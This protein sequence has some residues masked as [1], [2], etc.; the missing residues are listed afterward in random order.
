MARGKWWS[1]SELRILRKMYE[2]HGADISKW[3]FELDRS[4]N[5]IYVQARRMGLCKVKSHTGMSTSQRKR[6]R[7]GFGLLCGK[8]HCNEKTALIELNRMRE[9]GEI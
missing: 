3:E 5:A 7:E 9:R 1:D 4:R 6:L 2:K 8:L